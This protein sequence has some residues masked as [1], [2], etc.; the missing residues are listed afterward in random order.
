MVPIVNQEGRSIPL[1]CSP[2]NKFCYSIEFDEKGHLGDVSI[3]YEALAEHI[4]WLHKKAIAHNIGIWRVIFD[5]KLQPYLVGTERWPYLKKNI[6][7]SKKRSWVRHD[8]HIHVD[9]DLKCQPLK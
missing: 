7:F 9:F 2:L 4:Y 8:E 1:P 3:D 5:P 6:K